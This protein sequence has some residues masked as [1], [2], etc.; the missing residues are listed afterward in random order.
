MFVYLFVFVSTK[1]TTYFSPGDLL[2]L[3]ATKLTFVRRLGLFPHCLV[4]LSSVTLGTVSEVH[5]LRNPGNRYTCMAALFD[6]SI[7]QAQSDLAVSQLGPIDHEIHTVAS[8]C[9]D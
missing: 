7:R 6:H 2:F 5:A 3:S 4:T 1:L 8:T 9:L